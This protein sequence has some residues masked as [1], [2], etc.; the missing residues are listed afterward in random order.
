MLLFL[1][2][3]GIGIAQ[4]TALDKKIED[5]ENLVKKLSLKSTIDIK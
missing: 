4:V 5:A 1:I 2:V 3:V